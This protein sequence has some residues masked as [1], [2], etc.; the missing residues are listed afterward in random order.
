[1]GVWNRHHQA[2]PALWA[3]QEAALEGAEPSN[4]ASST[5]GSM[6]FQ[7]GDTGTGMHMPKQT[8]TPHVCLY[9]HT[10]VF[11]LGWVHLQPFGSTHTCM[12]I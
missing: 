11:G 10:G 7:H 12:L 3:G 8:G 4:P 6:Q 1:M 5:H 2:H 9:M